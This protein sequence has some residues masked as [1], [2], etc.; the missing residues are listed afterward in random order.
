MKASIAPLCVLAVIVAIAAHAESSPTEVIPEADF[1]EE[2]M[3]PKNG[4]ITGKQADKDVKSYETLAKDTMEKDEEKIIE[5]SD[6]VEAGT[7]KKQLHPLIKAK[8]ECDDLEVDTL[9]KCED[10]YCDYVTSC[11]SGE[12]KQKAVAFCKH[13]E[14]VRKKRKQHHEALHNF[15]KN[16]AHIL[17]DDLLKSDKKAA[18]KATNLGLLEHSITHYIN[19]AEMLKKLDK[20]KEEFTK[21][22]K[23]DQE[24]AENKLNSPTCVAKL[25]TTYSD[26]AM[27][28]KKTDKSCDEEF[29]KAHDFFSKQHEK[30]E[31]AAAKAKAK[32]VIKEQKAQEHATEHRQKI[33]DAL[34]IHD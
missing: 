16:A 32:E 17:K 22:V 25:K 3:S 1:L 31:Q 29:K 28:S 26:C 5:H 20:Q 14:E 10:D 15:K 8:E 12:M 4:P 21:K 27:V 11:Y 30:Y 6:E 18:K 13:Q 24:A 34:N 19:A 9:E 33:D 23:A 2:V 7:H